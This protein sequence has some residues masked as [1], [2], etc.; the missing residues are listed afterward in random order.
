MFSILAILAGLVERR[1]N[2]GEDIELHFASKNPQEENGAVICSYQSSI[3]SFKGNLISHKLGLQ[4]TASI[5]LLCHMLR[6]P[7]FD[8][9][10]TKQQLGYIVSAYYELG[11][12]SRQKEELANMG[13][14]TTPVDFITVAILSRKLPPPEIADRIDEFMA[15]FRESLVTMPESE[16]RDHANALSTSLLKPIQKLQTETS[17]HFSKIERYAPELFY[18]HKKLLP[19]ARGAEGRIPWDSVQTLAHRIR[20]LDRAA[21][22]ETW[23]RMIQPNSRS[24]IVSCVYGNTFPLTTSSNESS[25]YPEPVS[26]SWNARHRIKIVNRFDDVLEL[27]QHLE[28]FNEKESRRRRLSAWFYRKLPSRGWTMVGLGCVIGVGV[29]GLTMAIRNQKRV[30]LKR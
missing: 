4:S 2:P 6:E 22:L 27:R 26:M 20:T 7:L 3:P 30:A 14:L 15:G 18:R 19:K 16:I 23:D 29:V 25:V 21:L 28:V 10:R 12:S 13:P 9:L 5:R 24:R 11:Y 17:N 8:E 1:V